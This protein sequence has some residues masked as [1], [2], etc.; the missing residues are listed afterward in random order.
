MPEITNRLS[1][2]KIA[3][4]LGTGL[5]SLKGLSPL[6][7]LPSI[8]LK[9]LH[10][11]TSEGL[12]GFKVIGRKTLSAPLKIG[13]GVGAVTLAAV[14][15]AA[16][17]VVVPA[18]IMGF[19]IAYPTYK[20]YKLSKPGR[21][22]ISDF[23][24]NNLPSMIR[25]AV[26][27]STIKEL[28]TTMAQY[29]IERGISKA[30]KYTKKA[31]NA[32]G[33]QKAEYYRKAFQELA[34]AEYRLILTP[35]LKKKKQVL[36]QS[37]S[38]K[39]EKSISEEYGKIDLGAQTKEFIL[40][41]LGIE[42]TSSVVNDAIIY[43][44]KLINSFIKNKTENDINIYDRNSKKAEENLNI[45]LDLI[46]QNYDS[47]TNA[48]KQEVDKQVNR[49]QL[50]LKNIRI[51]D[52]ASIALNTLQ[53]ARSGID[54]QKHENNNQLSLNEGPINTLTETY[55]QLMKNTKDLND[56]EMNYL[57]LMQQEIVDVAKELSHS[58]ILD[59]AIYIN[60]SMI[61]SRQ[62]LAMAE[63]ATSEEEKK[64]H[65]SAALEFLLKGEKALSSATPE[66][67]KQLKTLNS[68]L[69]DL[70]SNVEERGQNSIDQV[71]FKTNY[72]YYLERLNAKAQ[73]RKEFSE[74]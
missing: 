45:A 41:R 53:K 26:G 25:A 16:A 29:R 61:N 37:I 51:L 21:E 66:E 71:Y 39:L 31:I 11:I 12:E 2:N 35:D 43:G 62:S 57:L 33:F 67:Q 34:I 20:L 55:I 7:K 38:E 18:V 68:D 13:V 60:T 1:L 24:Q 59:R 8:D 32:Q 56:D 10:K 4:S 46:K 5:E 19:G 50:A 22:A 15:L 52:R 28:Q 9:Q 30:H 65:Y 49:I 48:E 27:E 23:T 54:R 73:R 14:V 6:A 69:D 36:E 40:S 47:K 74:S 44:G 63:K 58:P 72:S 3:T 70:M 42:T 64:K 17:V